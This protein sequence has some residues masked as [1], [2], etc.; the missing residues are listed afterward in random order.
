M[1]ETT[2]VVKSTLKEFF[3]KLFCLES[4]TAIL[5]NCQCLCILYFAYKVLFIRHHQNVMSALSMGRNP[6][7][8]QNQTLRSYRVCNSPTKVGIIS[9]Y[10][11]S[12]RTSL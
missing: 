4:D 6:F 7:S 10:S 8:A 3:R 5:Q 9:S 11:C 2:S 1:T 12:N